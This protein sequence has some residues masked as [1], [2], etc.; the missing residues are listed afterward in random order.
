[1]LSFCIIVATVSLLP[2]Y[3]ISNVKKN[4]VLSKLNTQKEEP[5]PLLDQKAMSAIDELDNK[6]SLIE[7]IEKNKFSVS[8]E[9]IDKILSY[10][11]VDIKITQIRY[12]DDLVKGKKISINGNAPNRDRLLLFRKALEEDNSFTT[13]DLPISNFIKG[14]NIEFFLSLTLK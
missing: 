1:M 13:V 3:F 6:M 14:S 9:V 5:I 11:M 2:T 8:K 7:N 12:E 4:L 10:K